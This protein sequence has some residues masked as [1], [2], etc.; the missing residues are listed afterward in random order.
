MTFLHSIDTRFLTRFGFLDAPIVPAIPRNEKP[1]D[2]I[3]VIIREFFRLIAFNEQ[4][5]D[6]ARFCGR[7]RLVS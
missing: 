1:G 6:H 5:E 4:I 2:S 7:G 3:L